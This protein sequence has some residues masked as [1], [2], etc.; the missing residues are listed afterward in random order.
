M[1]TLNHG[2]T[3]EIAQWLISN[4]FATESEII[5]CDEYDAALMISCYKVHHKE[6]CFVHSKMVESV[7]GGMMFDAV[8]GYLHE[9]YESAK[10][11]ELIEKNDILNMEV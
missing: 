5:N 3:K 2:I 8:H 1:T 6:K 11:R 7:S 10:A 4:Q 9:D